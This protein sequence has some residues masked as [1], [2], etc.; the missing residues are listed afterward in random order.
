MLYP[1]VPA[2]LWFR[3]PTPCCRAPMLTKRHARPLNMGIAASA[4][5]RGL[6]FFA[7]GAPIGGPVG[8]GYRGVRAS[9]FPSEAIVLGSGAPLATEGL[10]LAGTPIGL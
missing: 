7:H 1:F 2:P 4:I 10:G 9:S 3:P 8:N 6:L 5:E